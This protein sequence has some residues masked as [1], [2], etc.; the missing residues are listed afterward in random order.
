MIKNEESLD[1]TLVEDSQNLHE[2]L[3]NSDVQ[4]MVIKEEPLDESDN[5]KETDKL[6]NKKTSFQPEQ[7]KKEP[8]EENNQ[9]SETDQPMNVKGEPYD[10]IDIKIEI[11]EEPIENGDDIPSD[12]DVIEDEGDDD[13]PSDIG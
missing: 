2:V 6:Q 5:I 11:K 4:N 3:D 13:I 8:L 9:I 1:E 7:V 10:S 12:I